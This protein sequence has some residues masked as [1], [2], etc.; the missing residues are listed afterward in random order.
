MDN[1]K[2]YYLNAYSIIIEKNYYIEFISYSG[3]IINVKST[4]KSP[5]KTTL[6]L[7]SLII[8][9]VAILIALIKCIRYCC[10]KLKYRSI[11]ADEI[12]HIDFV[13]DLYYNEDDD[14][15]V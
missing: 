10:Y 6:I 11:L 7:T 9:G 4:T 1:N 13:D 15:L 5:P 12:L 2:G 3:L 14:L 8:I